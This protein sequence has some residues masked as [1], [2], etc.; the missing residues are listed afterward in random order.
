MTKTRVDVLQN[1]FFVNGK[2]TRPVYVDDVDDKRCNEDPS[3]L[4]Y[5][6]SKTFVRERVSYRSMIDDND[7]DDELLPV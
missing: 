6:T 3:L 4:A 2:T 1:F 7:D 5:K